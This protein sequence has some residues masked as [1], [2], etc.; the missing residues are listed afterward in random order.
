MPR[1][2]WTDSSLTP[3]GSAFGYHALAYDWI[4]D[5][6]SPEERQRYGRAL[7]TWLRLYTDQPEI[8][9]KYGYWE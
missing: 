6:L 9:V 1:G 7:G 4:Y 3:D 5:A 2:R 8:L